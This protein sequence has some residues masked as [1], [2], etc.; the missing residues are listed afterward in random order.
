[1]AQHALVYCFLP[2]VNG[3]AKVDENGGSLGELGSDLNTYAGARLLAAP[4]GAVSC[5]EVVRGLATIL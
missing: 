1:L 3:G 4:N 5:S 2:C